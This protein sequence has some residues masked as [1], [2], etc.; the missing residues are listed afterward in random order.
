MRRAYKL[1][2]KIMGGGNIPLEYLLRDKF[3][4]DDAAPIT[5]PRTCEP[6][7]GTLTAVESNGAT[8]NITGGALEMVGSGSSYDHCKI[9][10]GV[11]PAKDS[12]L[13]SF[14]KVAMEAIA[15]HYIHFEG[16]YWIADTTRNY[17][18]LGGP[19][20]LVAVGAS[21]IAA[22]QI[23]RSYLGYFVV[24]D[25]ELQWVNN[26]SNIPATPTI[27]SKL[28]D[29]N[30]V[31]ISEVALVD[32][33]ANGY[34]AWDADFSTVTDSESTPASETAFDCAADF[35]LRATFTYETGKITTFSYRY[36]DGNDRLI[37]QASSG[38]A[39]N[40]GKYVGGAYTSL[41][42]VGG[43][44]A[45]TVNYQ[46]D[47]VGEGS[48]VKVYVDN[49]EKADVTVTDHQ[50]VSGGMYQSNQVVKD[51]ELST[52]PYPS[53]GIATDR[54]IAPQ[55]EIIST[56]ALGNSLIYLRDVTLPPSGTK[57]LFFRGT[58]FDASPW[59]YSVGVVSDGSLLLR[60]YYDGGSATRASAGA[61][62]VSDGDDICVVADGADI[63]VFVNNASA[64]SY[65]SA[66]Y[67]SN[68]GSRL[69]NYFSMDSIE[70][71]PRDVSS[72]LPSD[73]V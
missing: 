10:A 16:Q 64:C 41:A 49:V 57:Y 23:I 27:Y 38:G 54:V 61:A 20:D 44:F 21:T 60:E 12:G 48:S 37:A 39:L 8:L 36:T 6:G 62:T 55:E 47:V 72:L 68:I 33:P 35:H 9:T 69:F 14:S 7:P 58:E 71:F 40:V 29:A 26:S 13:A 53:L 28:Y 25:G 70:F 59:C 73:L 46:L 18:P 11:T 15:R 1:F 24:V 3:T 45:D 30:K 66:L 50:T 32:L 31:T 51:A 19:N 2:G 63:E 65:A 42:S 67:A 4:T 34:T 17:S 22:L 56:T 52:H 5:S 43:T